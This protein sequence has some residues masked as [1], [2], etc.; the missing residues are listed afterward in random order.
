LI[1]GVCLGVLVHHYDQN[2]PILANLSNNQVFSAITDLGIFFLM[3]LGGMELQPVKL[4]KASKGVLSSP[5]AACWFLLPSA[6]AMP[7]CPAAINDSQCTGNFSRRVSG[8][9]VFP[10]EHYRRR[11]L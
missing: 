7:I 5:A 2:F 1:S 4:L 11:D 3:L 8:R 9:S 10:P 6:S